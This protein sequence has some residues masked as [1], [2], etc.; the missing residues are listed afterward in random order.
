M[1]LFISGNEVV[2]VFAAGGDGLPAVQDAV[3][4]RDHDL[5]ELAE[6][7][8]EL[9][10]AER[11]RVD[12]DRT[13]GDAVIARTLVRLAHKV[14]LK[15]RRVLPRLFRR[16]PPDVFRDAFLVLRLAAGRVQV[17]LGEVPPDVVKRA[18]HHFLHRLRRDLFPACNVRRDEGEG[19]QLVVGHRVVVSDVV[20]LFD[21]LA[22]DLPALLH[23]LRGVGPAVFFSRHLLHGAFEHPEIKAVV[24]HPK[25]L[26]KVMVRSVPD[27]CTAPAPGSDRR[28]TSNRSTRRRAPRSACG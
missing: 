25:S 18:A 20:R 7:R 27:S 16:V 17:G 23:D 13:A 6:Q 4:Q 22:V 26:R 1:L 15:R 28:R 3:L 5:V 24:F 14:H 10:N 9:L 2:A 12:A 19:K 8:H 21:Q 11:F